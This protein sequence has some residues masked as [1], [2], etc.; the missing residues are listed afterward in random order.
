MVK[1][2]VFF[3][4]IFLFFGCRNASEFDNKTVKRNDEG[5]VESIRCW[6]EDN[7]DEEIIFFSS[8]G[9]TISMFKKYGSSKGSVVYSGDT[10][11]YKISLEYGENEY[12]INEY[13]TMLKDGTFLPEKSEY[14]LLRTKKNFTE[15]NLIAGADAKFELVLFDL[16]D[17]TL[18]N[19]DTIKNAKVESTI[20]ED[21]K[22][23]LNLQNKQGED[24]IERRI[25]LNFEMK[26]AYEDFFKLDEFFSSK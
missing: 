25:Y 23:L 22:A 4:V 26:E 11:F 10:I 6:N 17:S 16:N 13:L 3:C 9:D 21:K 12:F 1:Q 24:T 20:L 8:K 5:I 14:V 18:Q 7:D 15:F 19:G 2:L